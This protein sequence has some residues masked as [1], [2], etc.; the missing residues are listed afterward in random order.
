MTE[1]N[2]LLIGKEVTP[3]EFYIIE[4]LNDEVN[5][6]LVNNHLELRKLKV[7][8]YILNGHLTEKALDLI[9]SVSSLSIASNVKAK[10]KSKET[11]ELV[12]GES[13]ASDI[14]KYNQIYPNRKLDTGKQARSH[15]KNIISG[16]MWFF[17]TYDY[18]WKEIYK[19]TAM[20]VEERRRKDY[21]YMQNS[22]Y[23]IRK[24]NTDKTWNSSLADYCMSIRDNGGSAPSEF[25]FKEKI[26]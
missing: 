19:A 5:S 3:N 13:Y 21:T 11:P 24:Q 15:I 16:F 2:K 1:L 8:G 7:G 20:Y 25:V 4:C 6:K 9:K 17:K 22:Q 18:T 14:N 23:F 26:F 12:L 10:K